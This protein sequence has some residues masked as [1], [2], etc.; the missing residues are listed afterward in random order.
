MAEISFKR[1]IESLKLGDG[2]TFQGEGIIATRCFAWQP[3]TNSMAHGGS[4]VEYTYRVVRPLTAILT[5][6]PEAQQGFREAISLHVQPLTQESSRVWIIL[7]LTNFIQGEA[8]LQAFQDRIF[9]QDKPILENKLPAR[10]PLD[11]R[12]EMPIRCDRLS[13]AYRRFLSRSGV[14]FG[15]IAA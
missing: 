11:P 5:K 1:E 6:V 14:R 15:V 7:A 13:V 8:E 12:A 3:Q 10:L 2:Q 4:E 9:L